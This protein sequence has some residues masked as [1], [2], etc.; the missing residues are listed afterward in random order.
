VVGGCVTDT[1]PAAAVAGIE[2]VEEDRLEP[3]ADEEAPDPDADADADWEEDMAAG[4]RQVKGDEG[5]FESRL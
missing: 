4:D 5:V 3:E 1:P 2:T